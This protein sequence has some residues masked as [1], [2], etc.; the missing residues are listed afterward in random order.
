MPGKVFGPLRRAAPGKIGRARIG[1]TAD[2]PNLRRDHVAVR[3]VADADRKVDMVF[4]QIDLAIAEAQPEIDLGI[5][6]EKF[7]HDRQHMQPPEDD[8][9]GNS[10]F[11]PRRNVFARGGALGLVHL[12]QYDP[13]RLDIGA[14]GI[15]QRDMAARAD[16]EARVQMRL[17]IGNLAAHRGKRH[18]KTARGGRQA[19]GFNGCEEELSLRR[20]GPCI[21]PFFGRNT[22]DNP[23]YSDLM[24]HTTLQSRPG[25]HGRT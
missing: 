15:G 12:F 1:R 6:F 18:A 25:P 17:E 22:P 11:A 21:L 3:Q 23:F 14:P 5:G 2:R 13:A 24:E 19:S 4:H 10:Q 7:D 9:R 8:R 20:G 16:Q